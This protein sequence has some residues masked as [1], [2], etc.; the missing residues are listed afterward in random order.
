MKLA[1][2]KLST[3]IDFNKDN[4]KEVPK[5]KVEYNVRISKY[6]RLFFKL[7]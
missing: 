3:Y 2:V 7:V 1:D 6:K 4:N 5:F